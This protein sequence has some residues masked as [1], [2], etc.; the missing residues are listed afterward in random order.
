MTLKMVQ[1]LND[2]GTMIRTED[3][4]YIDIDDIRSC[5]IV[6][7]DLMGHL[8]LGRAS[9]MREFIEQ[10]LGQII[11]DANRNVTHYLIAYVRNPSE[12][13]ICLHKGNER[14]CHKYM[15][16]EGLSGKPN[17]QLE[18]INTITQIA[19]LIISSL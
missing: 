1:R 15:E 17:G 19:R 9:S 4:S 11:A 5:V 6:D 13:W 16:Q 2:T 14:S 7:C 10:E 18:I 3:N 8:R 12:A